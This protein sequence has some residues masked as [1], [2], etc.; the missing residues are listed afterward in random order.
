MIITDHDGCT[1]F[2]NIRDVPLEELCLLY[3]YVA[4]CFSLPWV[5]PFLLVIK[6]LDLSIFNEQI[7][8]WGRSGH[9]LYNLHGNLGNKQQFRCEDS[10]GISRLTESKGAG[11]SLKWCRQTNMI[12]RERKVVKWTMECTKILARTQKT[13]IEHYPLNY[14]LHSFDYNDVLYINKLA[15]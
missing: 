1:P 10:V 11:R 12:T 8:L 9:G 15:D 6:A 4:V 3:I 5:P 13:E 7:C 2:N 14:V